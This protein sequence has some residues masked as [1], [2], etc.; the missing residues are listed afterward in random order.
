MLSIVAWFG[1]WFVL[2]QVVALM[3]VFA[4]RNIQKKHDPVPIV[5]EPE[6]S[7]LPR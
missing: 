7:R 4:Y 2:T 5:V 6:H 3:A 1:V